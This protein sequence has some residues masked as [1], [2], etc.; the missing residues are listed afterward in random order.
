MASL[1]IV[2]ALWNLGRGGAERVVFDLAVEHKKRGHDVTILT[3]CGG[4][5]MEAE[6]TKAG[7]PFELGPVTGN[8][9]QTRAFFLEALQHD[10]CERRGGSR[11]SIIMIKTIHLSVTPCVA[12]CTVV[13]IRLSAFLKR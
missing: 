1:K 10:R 2:Q 5:L 4:G 13:P 11:R 8:R 6:F 3:A 12:L 7:I 9:L